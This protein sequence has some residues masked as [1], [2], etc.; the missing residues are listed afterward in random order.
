ME[1]NMFNDCTILIVED[2]P[3][4]YILLDEMICS[5][6]SKHIWAK[7]GKE[8]LDIL[9]LNQ[10]ISIILMDI[11]MPQMDGITATRKIREK[12]I[13][14]P[15]IFQTACSRDEKIKECFL[16]GGNEFL[17]K[18]LDRNKTNLVIKKYLEKN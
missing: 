8:A 3:T 12:K 14:I 17:S 4:N 11:D 10:S 13:N 1:N 18:P 5:F 9:S 2:D 15:I 7:N 6:G 16:A